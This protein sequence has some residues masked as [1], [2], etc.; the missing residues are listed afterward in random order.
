MH[1]VYTR[2]LWVVKGGW[3]LACNHG[4]T[5]AAV[6]GGTQPTGWNEGWRGDAENERGAHGRNDDT[7]VPKPRVSRSSRL[8]GTIGTRDTTRVLFVGATMVQPWAKNHD[9][10]PSSRTVFSRMAAS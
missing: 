2:S 10:Q 1:G 7:R 3:T 6:F 8:G 4:A 9:Y 5:T